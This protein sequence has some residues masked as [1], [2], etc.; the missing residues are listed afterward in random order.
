MSLTREQGVGLGEP[1]RD[2]APGVAGRV[3]DMHGE[4]AKAPGLAV[5]QRHV[6]AGYALLI[7]LGSDDCQL[8]PAQQTQTMY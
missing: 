6:Y 8:I 5:R 7:R 1:Q 3:H 4:A 2:V